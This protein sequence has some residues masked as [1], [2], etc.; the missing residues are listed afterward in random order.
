VI[1][2]VAQAATGRRS[3]WCHGDLHF[4]NVIPWGDG[5]VSE[6][7]VD[8]EGTTWAVPEYDLAQTLVTCDALDARD[9]RTLTDAYGRPVHLPLLQAHIVF[10]ALRGWTYAAHREGRD[11]TT[12]AARLDRALAITRLTQRTLS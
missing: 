10:Q 7:L 8:F 6:Y 12:W 2:A 9:L 5:Q 4:D 11:R 3:V 1:E